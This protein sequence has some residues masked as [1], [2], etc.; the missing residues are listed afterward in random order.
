MNRIN[1]DFFGGKQEGHQFGSCSNTVALRQ[2][3]NFGE[4]LI[5]GFERQASSVK[6]GGEQAP[7]AD[8]CW[9]PGLCVVMASTKLF[10]P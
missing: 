7:H 1:P 3:V 9:S 2:R 8:S 5:D 6:T 10:V 4:V